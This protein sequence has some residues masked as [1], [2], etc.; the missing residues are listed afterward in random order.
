[1]T[2]R[3]VPFTGRRTNDADPPL[4]FTQA[5]APIVSGQRAAGSGQRAA[6]EDASVSLLP[7]TLLVRIPE[8]FAHADLFIGH[9]M[10]SRAARYLVILRAI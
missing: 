7:S 5:H 2:R 10:N 6:G 8:F 9:R 4:F 3:Y 1:M